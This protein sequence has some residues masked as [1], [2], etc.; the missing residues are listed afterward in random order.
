M[1]VLE[2]AYTKNRKNYWKCQCECGNICYVSTA[3][4]TTGETVSC[5]CKNDENRANL[6]YL[7]RGLVDGTMKAAIQKDRKRNKN[8]TSGVTGVHF[9][10]ERG[11][12]VAQIMFQH[13]AYLL[14]RFKYKREAIK[15]RG[16]GEDKYF[17]KYR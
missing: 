14:G 9:D 8:N 3:Q 5:G 7:D 15:A 12:W 1:T 16:A 10:S 2:F 6:P 11:L 4:L 17:G 13:N